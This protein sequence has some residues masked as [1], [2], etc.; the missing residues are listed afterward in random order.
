MLTIIKNKPHAILPINNSCIH[1]AINKNLIN[2][3]TVVVIDN[4]NL[5]AFSFIFI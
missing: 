5:L 1:I 4:T 2:N 3:I